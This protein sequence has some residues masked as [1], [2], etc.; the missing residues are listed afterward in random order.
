M[1]AIRQIG[2]IKM[3]LTTRFARGVRWRTAVLKIITC[4]VNV[5]RLEKSVLILCNIKAN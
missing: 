4:S 3:A 5:D 2:T 1:K